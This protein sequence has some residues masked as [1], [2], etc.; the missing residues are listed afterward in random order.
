L[1][2]PGSHMVSDVPTAST[3]GR[4]YPRGLVKKS[5]TTSLTKLSGTSMAAGVVSGVVAVM[6][7]ANR[8]GHDHS[9]LTP[10]AI[11]AILQYTAIPLE[12][13]DAL[14]Q[15]AGALNAA[16]A[17]AL[18]A[19]IDPEA[20]V[21]AWWLESNVSPWTTIGS[22]TLTWGQRVVWGDRVVWGNQIFTNDPAWA[23]RVVW[24]DRVVWGNRVV[25][26]DSTVWDDGN[27]GVW[28][29]RVV[30][31]N[32]LIGQ[33][34]GSNVSWGSLSGNVDPTRV[35]WGDL[36]GLNIAP[37]SMSWGNLERANED[38]VAK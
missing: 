14:T 24:G 12:G 1:V 16:G 22:E 5:E 17:V 31:G 26:G 23:L 37:T 19:A 33:T 8:K 29:S 15:G 34:F 28:G 27:P 11:K 30:W 3:I 6:I 20:P 25:W 13:E 2:A 21:G 36:Q 7:E 4:L 38:L 18:A 32:S 9:S 35:V 10:N